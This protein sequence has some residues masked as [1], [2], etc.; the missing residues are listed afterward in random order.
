M[1]RIATEIALLRSSC[2]PEDL[3]WTALA[4]SE[5]AQ[6]RWEAETFEPGPDELPLPDFSLR[7]SDIQ[8][9][10]HVQYTGF[11]P[12]DFLASVSALAISRDDQVKLSHELM[13][14][15]ESLREDEEYPV[16]TLYTDLRE[17]LESHPF[18]VPSPPSQQ[19]APRDPVD[20]NND[21][22]DI[23]LKEVLIWSHH[24]LATGKRKNIIQWAAEL[25]IWG[26]AK[27]GYPGVIFLEGISDSVD[28]FVYRIKQLNWKALQIRYEQNQPVPESLAER[29]AIEKRTWLLR[30]AKLASVV[31]G[32]SGTRSVGA[33]EVESMSEF[34]RLMREAGLGDVFLNKYNVASDSRVR[35]LAAV[36]RAANEAQE[37]LFP[38]FLHPYHTTFA[39]ENASAV[40]QEPRAVL[41]TLVGAMADPIQRAPPAREQSLESHGSRTQ[42]GGNDVA[43]R[44]VAQ[45]R[46]QAKE[47]AGDASSQ[48]GQQQRRVAGPTREGAIGGFSRHRPASSS[49]TSLRPLSASPSLLSLENTT[50]TSPTT[51]APSPFSSSSAL[52][53]HRHSAAPALSS[54]HHNSIQQH[55]YPA[56]SHNSLPPVSA[57]LNG[58]HGAGRHREQL[59]RVY[60]DSRYDAEFD[61]GMGSSPRAGTSTSQAPGTASSSRALFIPDSSHNHNLFGSSRREEGHTVNVPPPAQARSTRRSKREVVEP[62]DMGTRRGGKDSRESFESE[63]NENG[64]TSGRPASRSSRESKTRRKRDEGSSRRRDEQDPGPGGSSTSLGG[65]AGGSRLYDHKKDDPIKFPSSRPS[66]SKKPSA[67]LNDNRS[68][69]SSAASD[70]SRTEEPPR[71]AGQQR[72]SEPDPP[73]FVMELKRA[74]REIT[75]AESRIQDEHKAALAAAAREDDA[76]Q[77]VRIQSGARRLD[78]DYWVRLANSHKQLADA[79]YSF[80]QMALDPRHPASLHSLPQKYNI[81]TRLW[82][83]AFHQLLER[84]RHAISS[85]PPPGPND[86]NVLDHLIEFIQYAYGFYSQLFEDSTIA[87]FRSAWIEQLGDLA[88]YRM[89]VAGLASRVSAASAAG[90]GR[91]LREGEMGE[92]QPR[93]VDAASIG[94]A[95]LGDWEVEEQES[96]RV[97]ARDWY[98]QGVAETPGTGRLQHHLALLSKGDEMR[99]LYHYAK[100]LTAHHPYVSAR[101]SILPLFEDEHQARRTQPDVT[102]AELFVHLHGMLFT[103]I[104]L[105]DFDD[106]VGRFLERLSEEGRRMGKVAGGHEWSSLGETG[107]QAPFGDAEWFMLATINIAALLQYGAEDGVL[108]KTST[109]EA[110]APPSAVRAPASSIVAH[111]K[112]R[113]PQAIMLNPSSLKRSDVPEDGED[114]E[115]ASCASDV[116]MR[117]GPSSADDEDPLVFRQAQ[118]LTFG[119]LDLALAHPYRIVGDVKVVN[120]YII[121]ILTFVASMAQHPAALR[122]LERAIPWARLVALFNIIPSSIEVRLDVQSKLLG[123]PL[124]EDWCIRGMDWTGKHVFGRGYWKTKS[125]SPGGGRRDEMTPP[126]I[127]GP[128]S[129]SLIESEMDALKFSLDSLDEF[130]D[131]DDTGSSESATLATAR[132]RRIATLA[133]WLARSVPGLDFDANQAPQSRFSV[134]GGLD[135]KLRRWKREEEDSAEA[136]RQSRVSKWEADAA[137][138][139]ELEEST[140]EEDEDDDEDPT[141]SDAVKELKA[142]RRE[143]KAIVRQARHARRPTSKAVTP[144]QKKANG[145]RPPMVVTFPGFTVLVFDTNILLT[146]LQ[147][148]RQVVETETW[149]VVVPLAVVTELDGLKR[150]A[151]ALGSAAD[152]AVT[153]LE[154]AI[155][156]R[157]R[158]IKVQTSR[159]NY[160]KDLSIRSES[161]DFAGSAEGGGDA[162][163]HD[164]ARSMDDVILRAVA[165]QKDHFTSR[166]ALVNPKADRRLVPGNAS[167]VVLVTFDRNLR[168]KARARGLDSTDEKGLSAMLLETKDA[169]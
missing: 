105:D 56:R 82:Q 138:V 33:F 43:D 145:N 155:R 18:A 130:A 65:Q 165:W 126:P 80:L 102:K 58:H 109:R 36:P 101:E 77:G 92:K 137:R 85:Q 21:S 44:W 98:G 141:D 72:R 27:P 144:R 6:L 116:V 25:E 122:H 161:I 35:F 111:S 40:E 57:Y 97:M 42:K 78:D 143:L 125:A 114:G 51:T 128:P 153:Y 41:R 9:W 124:P 168:L 50:P 71:G 63:D 113:T 134:A 142:R 26:I 84:M 79:H 93:A 147:L 55:S 17:W 100:S 140:E 133:A 28:E 3:V 2:P 131:E 119:M 7:L 66:S 39:E 146:S 163:S 91:G 75:D 83:I 8:V 127:S 88:R 94:D 37:I 14:R 19:P 167:N 96:W 150:N 139:E 162:L 12:G 158:H 157:S 90:A 54:S 107:P 73:P 74:Y 34:G 52:P 47:A 15:R 81:H 11:G 29:P 13:N 10:L 136:E 159:G 87:V 112:G 48:N 32:I 62:A 45:L 164:F 20:V 117:L 30:N 1:E 135:T 69:A 120:P 104:Q 95:A 156:Q 70:A 22:T 16:F 132:W 46:R 31:G 129:A 110:A 148:F 169:G 59:D 49:T 106:C 108:K 151:T 154:T 149:T 89:A 61:R 5:D 99:G 76:A 38:L 67:S 60:G 23:C 123:G 53:Q 160:L 115:T 86:T 118:R 166:L 103:K 64:N 68:L 121:L 24:L 4:G 152:D